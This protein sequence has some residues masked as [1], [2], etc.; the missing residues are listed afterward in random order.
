[1]AGYARGLDQQPLFTNL[2]FGPYQ[3]Y[4]AARP[5]LDYGTM[6]CPNCEKL[7]SSQAVWIE[8]RLLLGTQQDM[9][10]IADAFEKVYE[11]RDQ[12]AVS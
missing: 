1:M 6:P 9:D 12:L 11:N 7:C 4:Q 8:Q 2:A 10:D 5:Q 3:G